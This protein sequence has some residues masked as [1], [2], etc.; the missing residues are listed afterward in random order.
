MGKD[1]DRYE[2]RD[3]DSGGENVRKHAKFQASSTPGVVPPPDHTEVK[4][5]RDPCR[6][7]FRSPLL[8]VLCRELVR[9]RDSSRAKFT[10]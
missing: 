8:R 10:M 7:L 6:E 4:L 3:K 9:N 1:E 2:D 5:F